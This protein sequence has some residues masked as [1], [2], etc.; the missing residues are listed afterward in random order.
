MPSWSEYINAAITR[1][2]LEGIDEADTNANYLACHCLGLWTRSELRPFLDQ[3]PTAEQ[4]SLFNNLVE[5]RIAREPLQYII[6]ETEFFGLRMFCSPE[7]LIP[8]AE[9]EII[10]EEAL[11]EAERM[12]TTSSTL[13]ILDI[14][15]GSG[16]IILALASRLPNAE[17][18]GIDISPGALSLAEKNKARLGMSNVNFLQLD[19]LN[20][21]RSLEGNFD[22]IVSN[23]PYIPDS[24]INELAEEVKSFEPRV[25]LTDGADGFLFYKHIA[26]NAAKLLIS[27]GS[28][29]VETEFKGAPKVRAIFEQH[30]LTINRTATDLLSYERAIV[31]NLTNE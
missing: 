31:A 1:F 16:A 13:R 19:F 17:C 18:I 9:T 11:R 12:L 30:G 7:A 28:I 3:T 2:T 10:V 6:G 21:T 4:I 14:G 20:S 27:A 5:R 26:K 25:A 24:D 22:I 8:R 15:T 29:I 23:P